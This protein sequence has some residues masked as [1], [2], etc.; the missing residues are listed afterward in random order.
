MRRNDHPF[1]AER[2]PSLLPCR[3]AG[4]H[5][6]CR[7]FT[8]NVGDLKAVSRRR[9]AR[10]RGLRPVAPVRSSALVGENGAG[11]STLMKML[12]G[13]HRADSG[14]IRID[15]APVDMH[16]PAD[17]AR[18]GIGVI[19]QERE[20]I[21]TL[22]VAGNVFL[23]REP[24]RGGP[25]RLLDRRRMHADTE[26]ALARIGAALRPGH[27]RRRPVRGTAAAR[28]DRARPV[29]E[30]PAA[31]PRRAHGE[32]PVQRRRAAVRRAA[33]SAVPPGPPSSTSRTA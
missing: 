11:K 23:G 33:R 7:S 4:G 26:R 18:L 1:L 16:G 5:H 14:E 24:T 30:R 2:V 6:R 28:R 3:G 25:L 21:D 8:A 29:D 22:D 31:D 12:A 20:L 17:A 9:R 10:P 13:I 15:G 27:A 32:P 19:H